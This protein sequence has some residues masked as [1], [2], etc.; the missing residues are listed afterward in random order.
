MSEFE[1][2][3]IC[4]HTIHCRSSLLFYLFYLIA[5]YEITFIKVK[6]SATVACRTIT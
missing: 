6:S 4:L 1:D 3:K 5:A 2:F